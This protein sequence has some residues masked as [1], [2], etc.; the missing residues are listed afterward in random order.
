MC[1]VPDHLVSAL[2]LD[3]RIDRRPSGS[4]LTD[5]EL[6]RPGPL[7][8][9]AW[10]DSQLEMFRE[11]S[12]L[13]ERAEASDCCEPCPYQYEHVVSG[14]IGIWNWVTKT[15]EPYRLRD[16]VTEWRCTLR[17]DGTC[18]IRSE[19]VMRARKLIALRGCCG[20]RCEN[21][22]CPATGQLCPREVAD[23]WGSIYG[24][25]SI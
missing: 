12:I 9:T 16:D 14:T 7:Q 13:A 6:R 22:L 1:D 17:R 2:G 10:H 5:A 3:V 4:P 11:S 20:E 23:E 15:S 21:H 19:R 18:V 24:T 8:K 25:D